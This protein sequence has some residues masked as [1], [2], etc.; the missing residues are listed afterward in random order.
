MQLLTNTKI[1]STS[2]MWS[3]PVERFV[4]RISLRADVR[5]TGVALTGP[6]IRSKSH[7]TMIAEPTVVGEEMEFGKVVPS[8]NS[9]IYSVT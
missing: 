5:L 4:S 8:S 9:S 1:A 2:A 7:A 6:S 3:N